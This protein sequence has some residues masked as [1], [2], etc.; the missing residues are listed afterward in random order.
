MQAIETTK[1]QRQFTT[2]VK[3]A[4]AGQQYYVLLHHGTIEAVLI[5]YQDW[6]AG[7]KTDPVDQKLQQTMSARDARDHL[8]ECR[9][10]ARIDGIH[11]LLTLR[12][13]S[14]KDP[15]SGLRAALVPYPWVVKALDAGGPINDPTTTST[16]ASHAPE[17]TP[18]TA[19]GISTNEAR[20]GF[21]AYVT[22]AAAGQQFLLRNRNDAEAILLGYQQWL[23]LCKKNPVDEDLQ[24]TLPLRTARAH[25]GECRTAAHISGIHTL[26]TSDRATK[27]VL[28]PYL[29]GANVLR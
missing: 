1:A 8:G 10:A 19:I 14:R 24:Q 28:A 20:S 6:L 11:T 27:A 12:A 13:G 5:G 4:A 23:D 7:C 18:N 25:L 16:L 9:K 15:T 17:T 3:D 2:L 22:D 26:I 21:S 29:W